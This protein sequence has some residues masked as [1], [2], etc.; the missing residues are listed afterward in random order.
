M[1]NRLLVVV[2]ALSAAVSSMRGQVTTR[3]TS[4]P[5]FDIRDVIARDNSPA[6]IAGRQ[7]AAQR[8]ANLETLRSSLGPSAR[9]VANPYGLPKMLLRDGG[10]LSG[11]SRRDP[12]DIARD[13]LRSH[14]T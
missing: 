6:R 13:F 7:L 3:R 12:E 4:L 5:D 8:M 2:V 11:P 1:S 14:R 10:L 9:V